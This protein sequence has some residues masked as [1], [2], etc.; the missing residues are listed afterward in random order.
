M[1]LLVRGR[2]GD[3]V[4]GGRGQ[5]VEVDGRRGGEEEGGALATSCS[6]VHVFLLL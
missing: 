4:A 6:G 3:G 2:V 1:M 5:R